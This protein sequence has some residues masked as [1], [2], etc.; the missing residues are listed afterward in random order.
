MMNFNKAIASSKACTCI[1]MAAL[2]ALIGLTAA[3]I[4]VTHCRCAEGLTCK[5]K[6]ALTSEDKC[7]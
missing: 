5:A 1:G 2:G 4:L 6:K 7:C 3:K